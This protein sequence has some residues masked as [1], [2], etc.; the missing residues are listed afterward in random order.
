MTT[1]SQKI[2]QAQMFS[3]GF[4][5]STSFVEDTHNSGAEF[6]LINSL[7]ISQINRLSTKRFE[8]R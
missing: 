3:I 2:I 5:S 1:S 6:L 8:P 7:K 4:K